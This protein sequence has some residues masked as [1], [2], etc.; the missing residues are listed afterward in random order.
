MDELTE[1]QAY[2][3]AELA[4]GVSAPEA[5]RRAGYSTSYAKKASAELLEKPAVKAAVAAIRGR[6]NAEAEITA[7]SMQDAILADM[8]WAREKGNPM[9]VM[10]GHEMRAK[11]GG[12]MSDRLN[13]DVNNRFDLVG[14]IDEAR[15][16]VGRPPLRIVDT[17]ATEVTDATEVQK[18]ETPTNQEPEQ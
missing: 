5:A 18:G 13:I 8:D 1:R 15:A 9:A 2:F 11:L 3:V 12:L 17:T 16:R 7:K 14:A 6:I 4:K 10:K